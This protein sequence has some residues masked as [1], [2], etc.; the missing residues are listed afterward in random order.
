[1][2]RRFPAILD[3]SLMR[4]SARIRFM[5][6]FCE[7]LYHQNRQ[8]FISSPMRFT[9]RSAASRRPGKSRGVLGA[10]ED[11]VF[12]GRRRGLGMT[13]D[14]QRPALV[15][16]NIRTQCATLVAMRIVGPHDLKAIR[17]MDG[18]ARHAGTIRRNDE[19]PGG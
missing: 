6:D 18:R 4:K 14:Q 11:I 12:K 8:A 17:G 16:T 13:V 9:D 5:Q 1:V 10:M 2:E 3:V 19:I 7:S 15:N